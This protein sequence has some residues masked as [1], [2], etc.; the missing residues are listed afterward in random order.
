MRHYTCLHVPSPAEWLVGCAIELT[1]R[2]LLPSQVAHGDPIIALMHTW[3]NTSYA[4]CSCSS[5]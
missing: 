3:K 1:C 5:K 2:G 4:C